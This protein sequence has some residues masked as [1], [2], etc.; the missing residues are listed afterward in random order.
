[1]SEEIVEPI[2]TGK[3]TDLMKVTGNLI[4]NINYKVGFLLFMIGILIFSDLFIEN[5]LKNF[6]GS[7]VGE[8]TTTKGTLL[9]L[10]FLIIAYIILDLVVKYGFL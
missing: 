6:K 4:T 1:M 9:Q 8:C 2:E 7:T 3:K 5:V 10:M